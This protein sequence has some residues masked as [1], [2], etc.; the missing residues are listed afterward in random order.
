MTTAFPIC[1][2]CDGFMNR[3][4][5]VLDCGRL[6]AVYHCPLDDEVETPL[7]DDLA[8]HAPFDDPDN[9]DYSE[10]AA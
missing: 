8:L 1:P 3:V 10:A 9:H 7:A 5:Y 6:R 2:K 4:R